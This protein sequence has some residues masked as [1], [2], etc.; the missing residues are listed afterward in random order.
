M[1]TV[2]NVHRVHGSRYATGHLLRQLHHIAYITS[3]HTHYTHCATCVHELG[4]A[5]RL[6]RAVRVEPIALNMC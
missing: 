2:C 1:T 3:H 4:F 6:H 5:T